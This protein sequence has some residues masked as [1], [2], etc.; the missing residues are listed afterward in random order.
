MNIPGCCVTR[1]SSSCLELI[2]E[3]WSHSLLEV[4]LAWSTARQP[5]DAAVDSLADKGRESKLRTLNLCG[6]SV[7]FDPVKNI[8]LKCPNLDSVNLASCRA[9]PRGMKR[10]YTGKELQDLRDS[11]DPVKKKEKEEQERLAKEKKKKAQEDA[12]QKIEDAKKTK[13]GVKTKDEGKDTPVKDD[14]IKSPD[15]S[16]LETEDAKFG[17]KS[18]ASLVV[19]S[20]SVNKASDSDNTASVRSAEQDYSPQTVTAQNFSPAPK[21]A[22]SVHEP[23][24]PQPSTSGLSTPRSNVQEFS[25]AGSQVTADPVSASNLCDSDSRQD[26]TRVSGWNAEQYS[27]LKQETLSSSQPSPDTAFPAAG[28]SRQDTHKPGGTWNIGHYSPSVSR[29]ESPY[30]FQN[31]P[32]LARQESP[33]SSQKSP[34]V[35]R[36]ESPYST[37]KSPSV[38]SPYS[39][40]I[41]PSVMRQESPYSSQK[42]PSVVRQESPYSS[43]KSPYPSVKSPYTSHKSPLPDVGPLHKPNQLIQGWNL[44]QYNPVMRQE[45]ASSSQP[46]PETAQVLSRSA[47]WNLER[48]SP[49]PSSAMMPSPDTSQVTSSGKPCGQWNLDRFSPMA[50]AESSPA[51]VPSPEMSS[52]KPAQSWNLGHFSPMARPDVSPVGQPSP[53]TGQPVAK[54]GWSAGHLGHPSPGIVLP[55]PLQSNWNLGQFSP[56]GKVDS[57]SGVGNTHAGGGPLPSMWGTGGAALPGHNVKSDSDR[58]RT[59]FGDQVTTTTYCADQNIFRGYRADMNGPSVE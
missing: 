37:Q 46:S 47:N 15:N 41:S 8:L 50:R 9:L 5:L 7:S 58:T 25:P 13:E 21:S 19:A 23:F 14:Q 33:Y 42:S 20:P 26:A 4:D 56:M 52:V 51:A 18:P 44:D 12:K 48:F 35:V 40:Q 55:K 28:A 53:E 34:S 1:Q 49:M 16:S 45:S 57:S 27:P 11:F 22:P 24:S 30:S 10:H 3:K 38:N 31:S 39:S 17:I 36:H 43:Q 59:A 32:S 29:Q 2:C 6:S 54:A